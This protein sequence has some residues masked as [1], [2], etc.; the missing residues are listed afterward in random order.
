MAGITVSEIAERIR[1]EDEDLTT[2]VDRLRNWTKEGL[3]QPLGKKN[4]GT[5]RKR[6]YPETAII[7]ALVLSFLTERTTMTAVKAASIGDFFEK[8]R[9]FWHTTPRGEKDQRVFVI[10]FSQEETWAGLSTTKGLAALVESK[11]DE[12]HIVINLKPLF[13]RLNI[14]RSDRQ[15]G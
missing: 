11:P 4:P 1:R 7:D 2:V 12:V 13:E 9:E 8:A 3:L 5:G 6:R 14:S 10:S 15:R